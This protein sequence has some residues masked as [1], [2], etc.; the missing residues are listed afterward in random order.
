MKN[1][2]EALSNEKDLLGFEIKNRSNSFTYSHENNKRKF[3]YKGKIYATIPCH[4]PQ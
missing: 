3:G 2:F 1:I 4:F